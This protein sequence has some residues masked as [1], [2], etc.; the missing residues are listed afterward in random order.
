MSIDSGSKL[1]AVCSLLNLQRVL[2]SLKY[3]AKRALVL[4]E[5]SVQT[6]KA[7]LSLAVPFQL[8]QEC[9]HVCLH[10]GISYCALPSARLRA[11]IPP[12]DPQE[13]GDWHQAVWDVYQ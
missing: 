7:H 5:V 11:E 4:A 2:D 1:T 8:D 13:H 10:Y 12:D 3:T 6:S 9:P